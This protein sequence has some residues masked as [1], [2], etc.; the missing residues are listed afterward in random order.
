LLAVS[1]LAIREADYSAATAALEKA[2]ALAEQMRDDEAVAAIANHLGVVAG[3]TGEASS[4]TAWFTESLARWRVLGDEQEVAS[5]LGNL[6]RVLLEEDALDAA[7]RALDESLQLSRKIDSPIL[8]LWSLGILGRVA[9]AR[10]DL[11]RAE[12]LLCEALREVA[13]AGHLWM[14]AEFLEELAVVSG[15]SGAYRRAGRLWGAAEA[16]REEIGAPLAPAEMKRHEPA[17]Q[18]LHEAGEQAFTEA[19]AEGRSMGREVALAYALEV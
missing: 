8:V 17:I 13:R 3:L 12:K 16:L 19:L 5:V 10:C 9:A 6:G 14:V 18:R 4:S 1:L 11:H 15:A 7:E 2:H